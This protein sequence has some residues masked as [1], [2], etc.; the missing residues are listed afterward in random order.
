MYSNMNHADLEQVG[1]QPFKMTS[2]Y[3]L[4]VTPKP[5]YDYSSLCCP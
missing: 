3:I 5:N 1:L 2:D 4:A